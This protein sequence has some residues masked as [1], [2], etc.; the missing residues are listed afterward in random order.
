M[1]ICANTPRISTFLYRIA[2]AAQH[3]STVQQSN[4]AEVARIEFVLNSK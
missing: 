2:Q 1:P 3:W 4:H